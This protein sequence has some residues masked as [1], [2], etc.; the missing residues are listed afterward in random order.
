MTSGTTSGFFLRAADAKNKRREEQHTKTVA[1]AIAN[2]GFARSWSCENSRQC[3]EIRERDAI[4]DGAVLIIVAGL[5]ESGLRVDDFENRGFAALVTQRGEALAFRGEFGGALQAGEF[6]ERSFGFGVQRAN[7]GDQ[8]A[9]REG[10]F[11]LGLDSAVTRP[12]ERGFEW[13]PNSRREI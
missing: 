12:D 3:L 5:H 1:A 9:L 10:E 4:A 7:F 6:V 13:R 2:V 11:A 8:F